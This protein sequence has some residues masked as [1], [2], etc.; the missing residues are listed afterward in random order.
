M[1]FI[2]RFCFDLLLFPLI[3]L[4]SVGL[5]N[6]ISSFFIWVSI[7]SCSFSIYAICFLFSSLL[8]LLESDSMRTEWFTSFSINR[9]SSLWSES[10]VLLISIS[11]STTFSSWI[12]SFGAGF[13]FY[14]IYCWLV[15]YKLF[16]CKKIL[17][18]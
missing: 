18:L 6:T 9:T 4:F 3:F 5:S 13:S 14:P 17:I 10:C 8:S 1:S 2:D 11:F 12:H 7:V 16:S 15:N